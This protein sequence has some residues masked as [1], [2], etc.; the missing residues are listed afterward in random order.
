MRSFRL[1][2]VPAGLVVSALLFLSGCA[3]T[4]KDVTA[5]WTPEKIYKEARDEANSGAWDKAIGF[6]EKLEGRAAGT[7]LAQ[8]AQ[9]DKN[10]DFF[11]RPHGLNRWKPWLRALLALDFARLN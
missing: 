4:T 10:E 8:Q 9:I 6:Y 1:S 2:M 7:V 3:N 5:G 11:E